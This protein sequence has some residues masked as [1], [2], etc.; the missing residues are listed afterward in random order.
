M[1]AE[2]RNQVFSLLSNQRRRY[3]LHACQ[4]EERLLIS[5]LI[6]TVAAWE[7]GKKPTALSSDER[8]RVYTAMKQHHIPAMVNAGVIEIE[9][10]EVLLTDEGEDIEIYMDIVSDDSIPWSKYYL[11]VSVVSA[12]VIAVAWAGVYPRVSGFV[13][14]ALVVAI[15]G[16]SSGYH[17][18]RSRGMRLGA[19]E[20]PPEV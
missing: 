5:E 7:Y 16:I 13:W 18:Y 10:G 8:K 4:S 15:F 9:G 6:E 3:A 17:V 1:T 14:A 12:F 2:E 19:T 11:G 20:K